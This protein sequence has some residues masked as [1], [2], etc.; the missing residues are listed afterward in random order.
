MITTIP[1]A[2]DHCGLKL[3]AAAIEN[4]SDL[5]GEHA[6]ETATDQ[7]C[8][9]FNT[10]LTRRYDEHNDSQRGLARSASPEPRCP[11]GGAGA[12]QISHTMVS[13]EPHSSA[14]VWCCTT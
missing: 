3:Y 14:S 2:D 13:V 1:V 12:P 10:F 6:V 8:K 5:Y 9:R 4:D 7:V 11:L